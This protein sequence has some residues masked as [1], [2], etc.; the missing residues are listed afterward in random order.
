MVSDHLMLWNLISQ[1]GKLNII[2]TVDFRDSSRSFAN[3]ELYI[4]QSTGVN[5]NGC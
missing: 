4:Y 3:L 1:Y 5:I 2:I